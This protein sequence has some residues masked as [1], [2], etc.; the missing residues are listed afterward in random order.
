MKNFIV[1]IMISFVMSCSDD[2]S[3]SSDVLSVASTYSSPTVEKKAMYEDY[4]A[5]MGFDLSKVKITYEK[6]HIVLNPT[7][8]FGDFSDKNLVK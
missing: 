1:L 4:I 5:N 7:C 2:L 3:D 6:D 8:P